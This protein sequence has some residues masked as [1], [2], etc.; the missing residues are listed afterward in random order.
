MPC[1][2]YGQDVLV[3]IVSLLDAAGD[4][5]KDYPGFGMSMRKNWNRSIYF[6]ENFARKQKLTLMK[7]PVF[8]IDDDDDDKRI[9]TL[10]E[11]LGVNSF[12]GRLGDESISF[13]LWELRNGLEGLN[14]ETE[15][16]PEP[17][18]N[19]RILVA[20]EWIIQGGRGILRQSLLNSYSHESTGGDPWCA[21]PL[22]PGA[23]GFNLE[24]WGFWK[25]RFGELRKTAIESCQKPIDEAVELMAAL[26][27]EV[28]EAWGM[29]LAK[30][31]S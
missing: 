8:Q 31:K 13:G 2:H 21:G 3:K 17:V 14:D 16:A 28:A 19:T 11:W 23:R 25:R 9:F 18:I 29:S 12:L 4:P 24:R 27:T 5:W 26:E 7:G 6:P 10:D 20:T 22:F 1:R 30:D 15:P